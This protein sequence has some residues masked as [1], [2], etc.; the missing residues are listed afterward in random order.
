[1]NATTADINA[2]V[3][4][5]LG[6]RY[7]CNGRDPG[8]GLDC[9]GLVTEFFKRLK[10][11]DLGEVAFK[12]AT[13][14]WW[15]K[16]R[17][18]IFH[19]YRPDEFVEISELEPLCIMTFKVLGSKVANHSGIAL[20]GNRFFNTDIFSGC[21]VTKLDGLIALKHKAYRFELNG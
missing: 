16:E 3:K 19:I 5:M 18:E 14:N 17:R 8:V 1:M 2:V 12:Y 15:K 13:K 9:W 20:N 10:G 6:I 11:V 7:V 4:S 21:H